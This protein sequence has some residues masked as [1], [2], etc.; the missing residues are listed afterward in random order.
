VGFERFGEE[1][2]KWFCGG[3]LKYIVGA[4]IEA[5]SGENEASFVLFLMLCLKVLEVFLLE[6]EFIAYYISFWIVKVAGILDYLY[7]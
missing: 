2:N 1:T 7:T 6:F 4:K 3:G 5:K